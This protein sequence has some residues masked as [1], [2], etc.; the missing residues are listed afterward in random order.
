MQVTATALSIS[1]TGGAA[2]S[3]GGREHERCVTRTLAPSPMMPMPAFARPF[4]QFPSDSGQSAL[5]PRLQHALQ[6]I[7]T[8]LP[9][10]PPGLSVPL[11]AVSFSR[12]GPSGEAQDVTA[13]ALALLA[14]L[15]RA[16]MR[17][18]Q[19]VLTNAS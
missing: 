15:A 4:P 6:Q 17:C 3:R 2:L 11:S 5:V 10:S 12:A 14:Q 19:C 7:L 8:R 9:L 16:P 1:R 13:E 18:Q